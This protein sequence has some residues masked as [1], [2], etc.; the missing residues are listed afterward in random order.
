VTT[1][2]WIPLLLAAAI[3]SLLAGCGGG[4]TANVQNPQPPPQ[5][6]VS[7]DFNPEPAGSLAVSFSENLTAVV[8][9]DP[10][11]LGVDWSLVC[12]SSIGAGNCGTLSTL[13]TV[14]G[15]P[16]TYTAPSTLLTDSLAVEVIA[17]ATASSD[18]KNVVAPIMISSFDASFRAG[19]YILQAQGV[20]SSLNPYQYAAAIALDGSGNIKG[21][22][23][24]A[25]YASLGSLADANLTG[26]YFI[27]N[28]G[29][30]TITINTGDDN[31]GANGV[32]TFALVY[33][34][35]SQALTS[36][37][38]F[39]AAATGASAIGTMDLQTST[40][41]PSRGYAFAVSGNDFVTTKPIALGGVFNVDSPNKIS[42]SGSVADE[43]VARKVNATA[44]A[45][46]GTLTTPDQFGVFTLNLIAPFGV[47]NKSIPLQ[48][49]GY[50]V[51]ETH[52]KL[53]ET[54]ASAFSTA[55]FGSTAGVAISQGTATG[56]FTDNASFSGTYVFEVAGVDL[57]NFN[58]APN[59]LTS[60][61]L[62]TADGGGNFNNG[63]TD[64]FLGLNT[65]QGTNANPQTG[66]QISAAFTG[67]YSVDSSGTGRASTTSVAFNPEPKLG[68]QPS[69]FFYLTGNGNP[70]LV[71]DAG[72]SHYPSLGAGIAYPQSSATATLS[73]DYGLIFTQEQSGTGEND[74]TAQFTA[75]STTTPPSLSGVADI[76]LDFGANLDQP[77]TGMFAAP[78]ATSPFSGT[79]VGTNNDTLSSAAF[80]PQIAVNYYFIDQSHGFFVETDLI[81][82]VPPTTPPTPS[83]QMSFGYYAARTPVCTGCP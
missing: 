19:T 20:D 52:I 18:S 7:I 53:I 15:A 74:A 4:S 10:S 54:D 28:D 5:S 65:I 29:R 77:F 60:I 9:N 1:K 17:L 8:T 55:P 76:N 46:S 6:Q 64:T 13:H 42:G 70:T 80:T 23:Q 72:D 51:D 71:L 26:S 41:A 79:L 21:G 37:I 67:T 12:P 68:Y 83:G 61:G 62:F 43:I 81:N 66:A 56:T 48:F 36:Q 25:N 2:R 3:T 63:F 27:G 38:D 14:S 58:L 73:G 22:E 59:T 45:L 57:S 35:N 11:N 47:M 82:S 30:G 44:V 33:L 69:F 34:N 31:I 49:A 75:N 78:T 16:N 24:T 40:A 32:E 50:I 39:G